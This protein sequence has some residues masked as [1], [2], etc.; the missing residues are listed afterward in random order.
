[1]G[2]KWGLLSA[3]AA[4]GVV[5]STIVIKYDGG[6]QQGVAQRRLS[7]GFGRTVVFHKYKQIF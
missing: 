3:D 1:V 7:R 5:R 6:V 4:R 2:S